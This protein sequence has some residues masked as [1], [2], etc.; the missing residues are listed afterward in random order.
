LGGFRSRTGQNLPNQEAE[1]FGDA[2]GEGGHGSK[3]LLQ[4][5]H[6]KMATD[7]FDGRSP[8][9][10][11]LSTPLR[12]KERLAIRQDEKFT[13][14]VG[15]RG[16]GFPRQDIIALVSVFAHLGSLGFR[17]RRGFGALRAAAQP[18]GELVDM[19]QA[20][21]A[22]AEPEA[23]TIKEL[24][25][26]EDCRT[27]QDYLTTL[28]NWLQGWRHHGQMER[29]WKWDDKQK[30]IGHWQDIVAETKA[31]NVSKPGFPYAR[32]DHNEGLAALGHGRPASDPV[33]PLGEDDEV[34]RAAL[35][36]PIIQQY[37]SIADSKNPSKQAPKWRR[38]V[39]W[40]PEFYQQKA[41]EDRD[42]KGEGRFASPVLLRPHK[43]AMGQW[44]ALVIFVDAHRWPDGKPVYLN[45]QQRDVAM[46]T[47]SDGS[48]S[49]A[50]YEAMKNDKALKPF[51]G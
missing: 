12:D 3:L 37:S 16:A 5:P 4:V 42:Y 33:P 9:G 6:Q 39:K 25:V 24:A 15:W 14:R 50:L 44:H 2:A 23:V 21:Q 31:M 29:A 26:L 47:L 34:F 22:F 38:E 45:G 49:P 51:P 46:V 19:K 32:R 18:R 1:I 48:H 36:L 41:E 13:L 20:L 17:S 35:G 30:G 27:W 43:D 8:P 40:H 10:Y 28:A 11:V 7:R